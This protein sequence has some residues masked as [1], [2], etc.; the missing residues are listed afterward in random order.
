VRSPDAAFLRK[1]EWLKVDPSDRKRFAHVCPDFIIELLSE[2]DH[3]R[4]LQEK[5]QEWMDNGCQLSWINPRKKETTIYR[6]NGSIEIRPFH[7]ILDGEDVLPGF[8]PDLTKIFI[9]E[10]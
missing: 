3:E 1:E 2:T 6:K 4:S 9:E 5:M 7:E 8:T 10:E